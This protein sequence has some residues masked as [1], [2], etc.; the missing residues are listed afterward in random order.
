LRQLFV[1]GKFGSEVVGH[2]TLGDVQGRGRERG[3]GEDEGIVLPSPFTL[4][5][6]VV[7]KRGASPIRH[8]IQ[9]NNICSVGV[10]NI[11]DLRNIMHTRTHDPSQIF[12][13]SL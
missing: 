3:R 13:N 6:E 4:S 1:L 11:Q 12:W 2:F 10:R 5:E 9:D 8:S 7:K